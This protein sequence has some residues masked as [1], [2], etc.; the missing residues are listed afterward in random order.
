MAAS[1][2]ESKGRIPYGQ[3]IPLA[4]L[5]RGLVEKGYGVTQAVA[6]VLEN[7]GFNYSV[8]AYESVRSA[9]YKIKDHPWPAA[10]V[11]AEPETTDFE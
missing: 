1:I 4:W 6:H 11:Q 10:F 2:G 3:W 5:T 7:S 8:G 9:Y